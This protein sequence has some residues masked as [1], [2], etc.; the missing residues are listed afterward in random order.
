M[1]DLLQGLFSSH[2]TL[3]RL[4][5]GG[6]RIVLILLFAWILIA[7]LQRGIR[8]LRIRIAS[9][10]ND[11][12]AVKYAETL[13]WVFRQLAAVAVSVLATAPTSTA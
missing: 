10:L 3:G 5:S 12:E 8:A 4:V 13:G 6:G 11:R 9:R 2:E 1:L 7:M